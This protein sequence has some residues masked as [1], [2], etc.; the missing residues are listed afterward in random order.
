MNQV[1]FF[2]EDISFDLT[3]KEK[4]VQWITR[5]IDQEHYN[6]AEINYIFCSDE[7]LH[8]INMQYLSHDT[9]TDIVTFDNSDQPEEI[10]GDIFIS[11]E[12]VKDNAQ[13]M[14]ISFED[15]LHRV[16]IHGVLHLMGYKDK[17]KE[18]KLTMRQK[19]EACLSL[20]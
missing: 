9:Y 5:S 19:E 15:E 8:G 11:I 16:M 10:E 6:L 14:G 13:Q 17:T 2:E 3:D 18:Q 7:Y 20:R 1:Q 4:V 12:R